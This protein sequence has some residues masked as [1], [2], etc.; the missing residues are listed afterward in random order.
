MHARRILTS[1]ALYGLADICG[2]FTVRMLLAR[3]LTGQSHF[4]LMAA[5]FT[6]LGLIG[7]GVTWLAAQE[8]AVISLILAKSL[9]ACVLLAALYLTYPLISEKHA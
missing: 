4:A 6:A 3:Q 1:V 2:A 7:L 5:A 8:L 9:F